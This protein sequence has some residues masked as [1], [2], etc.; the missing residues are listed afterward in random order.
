MSAVLLK[1]H[2]KQV[3]LGSIDEIPPDGMKVPN[4]RTADDDR[5]NL[6]PEGIQNLPKSWKMKSICLE[7]G[8]HI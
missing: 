3:L 6:S 2:Q 4:Y 5:D 8:F 7:E 1:N